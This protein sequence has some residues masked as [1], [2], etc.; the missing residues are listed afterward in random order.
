[1]TPEKFEQLIG[2]REG[3]KVAGDKTVSKD[4]KEWLDRL[5]AEGESET[6]EFKESLDREAF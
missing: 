6:V 3:D 1:L 4:R 5:L 2:Q